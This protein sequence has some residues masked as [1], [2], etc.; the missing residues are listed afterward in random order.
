MRMNAGRKSATQH[1]FSL[2]PSA[3][4]QRS[5]FDRSYNVKTTVD[6]AY[7]YPVIAQEI[8]PGDTVTIRP[9]LFARFNT[10]LYPIMENVWFTYHLFFIPNRLIWDNWVKFQ[11]EQNNPGDSVDYLVPQIESAIG[12]FPRGGMHD[13]MGVPPQATAG[14]VHKV[15]ALFSR[16]ANLV[17]NQ[18]YRDQNLQN[19]LVVDKDDGPDAIADYPLFKR[20]KA[21]DYFTTALPWSQKG[22]AVALPLGTT[23]P[24]K[25]QPGAWANQD[26]T[27]K[28]SG[29][30]N[31]PSTL[32]RSG[33]GANVNILFESAEAA[34][35]GNNLRFD[36]PAIDLAVAATGG[37]VPYADLSTATAATINQIRTAF[38]IQRLYERDARSGT[39]YVEALK[40][41]FGV[42]SPDYRL[43][44]SEF[45]GGG[46][47]NVAIS[48]VPGTNQQATGQGT[49]A[50]YG[51]AVGEFPTIT[52]S[53]TEHGILLGFINVRADLSYQQG[54]HKMWSRRT[55][56]DFFEPVLSHLGEQAILS[57][58]IY[59]DGSANDETVFGYQER[60]AEYRYQQSLITGK[61]RSSDP[62][63]LDAWH[64]AQQF[65]SRPTLNT[66]F[67][68]EA[69]P[70]NRVVAFPTEPI[71]E[72]DGWIRQ[73]FVRPMPA[74]SVPGLIDHF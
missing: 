49:L 72:V 62:Q 46:R 17:Y 20:N 22:T 58:E 7:L 18:W 23:A 4:I 48:T 2:V 16:A 59:V 33:T 44:R 19:S 52:Q 3:E 8:L 74:Y 21:P 26:I 63:T 66:T 12:G 28:P 70:F 39:R 60:W 31:A 13:Y 55:R 41:R 45:L 35:A 30:L 67:I 14:V 51:V 69:P 1:D 64:L 68:T 5:A 71:F 43:Q 36:N 40:A 73:T 9:N 65:S 56:F 61:M 15:N 47:I 29:M 34:A 32:A 6:G 10:L 11:G 54:L 53:F 27:L 37:T 38:Q 24:L 42:T 57:K 50:G 25:G